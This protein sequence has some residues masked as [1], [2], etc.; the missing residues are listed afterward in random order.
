MT[1][2]GWVIERVV[3][4]RAVVE[5][6]DRF[7]RVPGTGD[8]RPCDRCTRSHE[9]HAYVR[10]SE[11]RLH[12]VGVGC[13]RTG[14]PDFDARLK[15]AVSAS[16]TVDR[17]NA[18]LAALRAS[19]AAWDASM[20]EARSMTFPGY[21]ERPPMFN[22]DNG[23]QWV[24]DLPGGGDVVIFVYNDASPRRRAEHLEFLTGDWYTAIAARATGLRYRPD[25][26]DTERRLGRA[27]KK[28]AALVG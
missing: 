19:Q 25:S 18:E 22:G 15:S 14:D 20:A 12:V 21:V 4:T 2:T 16:K 3:D 6:G 11:G 28:L 24:A 13:A 27:Q 10:D 1:A 23:V 5:E 26:Y 9:V 8:A 17:L 7:V